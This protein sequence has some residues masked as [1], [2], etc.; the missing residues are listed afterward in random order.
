[1]TK[2]ISKALVKLCK[3]SKDSG[4]T[5]PMMAK[6]PGWAA[7]VFSGGD[8]RNW[9]KRWLEEGEGDVDGG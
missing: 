1:M 2:G 8:P 5:V 4:S 6:A 7:F 9:G 3:V